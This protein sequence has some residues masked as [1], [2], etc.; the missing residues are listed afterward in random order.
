MRDLINIID[1]AALL[2]AHDHVANRAGLKKE[3]RD[4]FSSLGPTYNDTGVGVQIRRSFLKNHHLQYQIL[5]DMIKYNDYDRTKQIQKKLADAKGK[6]FH[7][8][9]SGKIQKIITKYIPNW[10]PVS[11]LPHGYH[12]VIYGEIDMS[13]HTPI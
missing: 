3:L 9:L 13:E 10:K 2:E 5:I 11:Y 1:R 6:Y 12:L 7:R 8:D 4:L